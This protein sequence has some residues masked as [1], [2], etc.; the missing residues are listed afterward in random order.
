MFGRG[1][2]GH[3]SIYFSIHFDPQKMGPGGGGGGGG[4]GILCSIGNVVLPKALVSGSKLKYS[5]L[6][7]NCKLWLHGGHRRLDEGHTI[8]SEGPCTLYSNSFLAQ[9]HRS[10]GSQTVV[11][12]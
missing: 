3:C 10:A 9:D 11:M 1:W 8:P 7:C 4:G 2:G 5:S 6:T 12:Q